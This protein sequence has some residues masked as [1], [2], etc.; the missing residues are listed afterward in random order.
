MHMTHIKYQI[1]EKNSKALFPFCFSGN[2]NQGNDEFESVSETDG[3]GANG[4]NGYGAAN[5]N[6]SINDNNQSDINEGGKR[7]ILKS[8]EDGVDRTVTAKRKLERRQFL[9]SSSFVKI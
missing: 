4:G 9:T 8:M 2:D 7:I 3:E 6:T 5:A 1:Y